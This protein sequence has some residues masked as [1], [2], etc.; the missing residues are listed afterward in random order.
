MT[1]RIRKLTVVLDRDFR[2]DDVQQIIDAIGMTKGVSEVKMHVVG[3]EDWMA[4]ATVRNEMETLLMRAIRA[5]VG[6]SE[7]DKEVQAL[8]ELQIKK[9]GF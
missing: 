4:R 6:D 3:G 7:R 9:G 1:D 2:S 8:L 5:I